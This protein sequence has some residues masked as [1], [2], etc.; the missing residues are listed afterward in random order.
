MASFR[1]FNYDAY[2]TFPVLEGYRAFKTDDRMMEFL[3]E[4]FSDQFLS[5][6]RVLE[7]MNEFFLQLKSNPNMYDLPDNIQTYGDAMEII[8]NMLDEIH[9]QI[10]EPIEIRNISN[11]NN[12]KNNIKND[13]L[14]DSASSDL[15][16]RYDAMKLQVVELDS[17]LKSI[18]RR[19]AELESPTKNTFTDV[20]NNIC[21]YILTLNQI[22]VHM[23][24]NFTAKVGGKGLSP[25]C[26]AINYQTN[27][28]TKI[29]FGVI[30]YMWM[31][32]IMR[33]M[34]GYFD[35]YIINLTRTCPA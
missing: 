24:L 13:I 33:Y 27:R 29:V 26:N 15:Q 4:V 18:N 6:H 21:L 11:Y 22:Y 28:S 10:N 7:L 14:P 8:E 20:L 30:V 32:I 17:Q 25:L 9:K 23:F 3:R 2:K 1:I 35:S 19:I 31:F 34:K 16:I 5:T 12:I